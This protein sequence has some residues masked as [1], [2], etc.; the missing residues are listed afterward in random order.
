MFDAI[1]LAGASSRRLDGADKALVEIGGRTLLDLV[2]AAAEGAER[3][4]VAGPRREIAG[5][6]T[7]VQ[8]QPP[9]GGPVAGLA[10]ALA[11]VAADWVLVLATDLPR[12]A[13][14]VPQ[15]LTAAAHADVA[16]LER[17]GRRNHLAAVWRTATLRGALDRLPA[18]ADAAM[19][20]LFDAVAVEE[21]ADTEGW[22]VDVD[23]WADL[24]ELRRG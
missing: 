8:E 22:G 6:V 19:R 24:E 23:T 15:L 2:V 11:E 5:E 1:V 18:V 13:A 10:A 7:W 12:V 3:V 4:I 20:A 14:A 17:D 16:V 9:G 21:V